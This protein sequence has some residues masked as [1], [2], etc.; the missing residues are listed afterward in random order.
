MFALAPACVVKLALDASA[1][2]LVRGV[3]PA[4]AHLPAILLKDSLVAV[5]WAYGL[6]ARTIEWRGN[7]LTVG[8]GTVVTRPPAGTARPH[9][10]VEACVTAPRA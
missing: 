6:V 7:R 3:G 8:P 9:P 4:V 5:A 2:R 1:V 10:A